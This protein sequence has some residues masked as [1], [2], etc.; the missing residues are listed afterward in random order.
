MNMTKQKTD[1]DKLDEVVFNNLDLLLKKLGIDE[2]EEMGDNIFMPCPVHGNS[3]NARSLSISTKKRCWRCW[4]SD[5]HEEFGVKI[6]GFVRGVLSFQ[7]GETVGFVD[8]LNFV[9]NIYNL[10]GGDFQEAVEETLQHS[11]LYDMIKIFQKKATPPPDYNFDPVP[12]IGKSEYFE[13]RGF[14]PETLAYFGVEDCMDKDSKMF[15]RV[16]IPIHDQDGKQV[17]YI[18]R[19]IK[20]FMAAKYLYSVGL[21]QRSLLYNHHRA[22]EH[23]EKSRL[24]L[25]E[26]QGDVWRMHDAGIKNCV[27]L[28]GKD[29]S[30]D[31]KIKLLSTGV[32]TLVILTDNDQPGRDSKMKMVRDMNRMFKLIFPRM[33]KKDLGD[34]SIDE[35][36]NHI[37]PQLEGSK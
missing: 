26:G 2:Y 23:I 22:V 28:F 36:H 14:S 19:R 15:R 33:R 32:T 20:E 10:D 9:K 1:L 30:H 18:G 6:I 5:C 34:T 37:L 13:A 24:F 27:G 16:I 29:I 11:D 31:Q 17:G 12:T 4:T 3:D 21:K 8:A 7:K 25:T 35:I